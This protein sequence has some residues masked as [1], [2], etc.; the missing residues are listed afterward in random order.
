MPLSIAFVADDGS[1]VNLADMQPRDEA[2]HCSKAP[3]RY[4]LEMPRGWFAKRGVKPGFRL[5]GAP[6]TR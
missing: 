1:I 6:F 5:Q 3:V 4:A 2:S